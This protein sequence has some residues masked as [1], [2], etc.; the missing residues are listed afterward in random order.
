MSLTFLVL[1]KAPVPGRVKTRLCPPCTPEQAA[2]V[3]RAALDDTLSTVDKCAAARRVLVVDGDYPSPPGWD[4]LAQRGDGLGERLAAAFA[5]AATGPPASGYLLVGMDTPQLTP[6]LAGGLVAELDR[7]DAVLAP[8][9]D[10][11]WWA[12]AL[13]D[14]VDAK[15]LAGVPMSTSDTGWLTREALIGQGLR[16]AAGPLLRD[17][18]TADDARTVAR[19]CPTGSFAAAVRANGLGPA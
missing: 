4:V 1:A 5:D 11:G 3:A 17:V 13:R 10:G 7:A 14:P 19:E 8:A 18:D 2:R 9:V 16:V 12:L 15:V 6:A